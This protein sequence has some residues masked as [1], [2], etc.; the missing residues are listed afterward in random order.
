[1]CNNALLWYSGSAKLTG[2]ALVCAFVPVV[3]LLGI[4]PLI[5]FGIDPL[6]IL[7]PFLIFSIGVSHA[8][9]MTN[10]WK[11]EVVAGSDGVNAAKSAFSNLFVPGAMA[12]LANAVGF[13]VMI[14]IAI[15]IVRELAVTA[16]LGV[17]VMIVTNKM[18]LTI[19]LS[20][21]KLTPAET[22]KLRKQGGEDRGEWLWKR[23]QGLAAPRA[24]M[25]VLLVKAVLLTGDDI[26]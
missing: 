19:L 3:W 24:A 22:E 21:L 6:S 2:L 12:L 4:L 7:V 15:D 9:Q 10:A 11:M 25:V 13:M 5:G 18:L 1:M 20:Y 8:V 26:K 17:A 16:S 14:Y 23:I